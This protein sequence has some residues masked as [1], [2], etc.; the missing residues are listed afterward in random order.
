MMEGA[1]REKEQFEYLFLDI[2]W[3]QASGTSNLDGRAA[4]QIGVVAA[5]E[6][7]QKVKTF[8][9]GEK[10]NVIS[11]YFFNMFDRYRYP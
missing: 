4:I 8:S 9:K 7:I 5:D 3:N 1:K 10:V 2:E 11:Q 6:Q